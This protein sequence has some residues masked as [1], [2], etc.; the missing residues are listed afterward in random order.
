MTNTRNRNQLTTNSAASRR[1]RLP[2]LPRVSTG[3][4]DLDLLL[5]GLRERM[6]V[7]EG[8]RGNPFERVVTYR[9]LVDLGLTT[10][11][12]IPTV[13]PTT[14]T[15]PTNPTPPSG[16]GVPLSNG[17]VLSI[18]QFADMIRQTKLFADLMKS[19]N[20]ATRFNDFPVRVRQELLSDLAEEARKRG[21]AIKRMEEKIQTAT[22]S[23]A[24]QVTTIT[25]SVGSVAAGVRHLSFASASENRATAAS[26]TQVTARLDDFDGGGATVEETL[27]AV[28]D[29]V[30]GLEAK[31]TVKVTAGGAV[32]GFGLAATSNTAGAS[33]A[34]IIQADKFAIVQ[35]SYSGGLDTTPDVANVPFGVDATGVYVNAPLNVNG[36]S[37]INLYSSANIGKIK[38]DGSGNLL[39]QCTASNKKIGLVS[40]GGTGGFLVNDFTDSNVTGIEFK[41]P[42]GTQKAYMYIPNSGAF[43]LRSDNGDF[44]LWAG[45]LGANNLNLKMAT[46]TFTGTQKLAKSSVDVDIRAVS[47]GSATGTAV[48]TGK[49]GSDTNSVWIEFRHNGT[50]YDILAW[51]RT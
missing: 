26:V 9:D 47:S 5:E 28:A 21:A 24:Q 12:S 25:A 17:Q 18:D 49:A 30:T 41:S 20:D 34:F 35:S 32:A 10:Q 33:S 22:S 27:S 50:I 7:R 16:V 11:R 40:T 23:F 1:A 14:S 36:T 15:T 45:T 42:G 37:G 43:W 31:Y 44:D 51:P 6:E 4:R 38:L 48:L 46:V 29:D 13:V 19:T 2:A 3:N 39:F 8:E